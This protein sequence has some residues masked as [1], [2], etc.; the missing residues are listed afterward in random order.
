MWYNNN[1]LFWGIENKDW[2]W[3]E[4]T[5]FILYFLVLFEIFCMCLFYLHFKIK[6]ERE[7]IWIVAQILA[8]KLKLP[9]R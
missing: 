8:P 7:H 3:K 4:T 9:E 5:L 2:E 6:Q 1:R